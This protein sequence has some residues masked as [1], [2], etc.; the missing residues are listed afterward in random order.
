MD[1]PK[2]GSASPIIASSFLGHDLV[3]VQAQEFGGKGDDSS[4]RCSA[5]VQGTHRISCTE[6]TAAVTP[7]KTR[8]SKAPDKLR[9]M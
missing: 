4:L 7:R 1:H 3:A 2:F 9:I 8:E 5:N 6:K